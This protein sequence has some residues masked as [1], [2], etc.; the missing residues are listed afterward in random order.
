[1][2]QVQPASPE[3][4][5]AKLFTEKVVPEV[6]FNHAM[7]TMLSQSYAEEFNLRQGYHKLNFQPLSIYQ[8]RERDKQLIIAEPLLSEW[9][10]GCPQS[11]M[12]LDALAHF[13]FEASNF[14]LIIADAKTIGPC[15]FTAPVIHRFCW[16][17][18]R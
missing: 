17:N 12:A 8:L 11:K 5:C 7:S 6:Y 13:S 3:K 2:E 10:L 14:Q 9:G 18:H 15:L 4:L 16:W 1:M